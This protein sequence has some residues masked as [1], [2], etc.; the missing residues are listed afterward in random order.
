MAE[1]HELLGLEFPEMSERFDRF[2]E[3]LGYLQAA[4][5]PGDDGFAGQHYTLAARPMRPKPRHLP[6]VVGG[7]GPRRTPR[8]AGT[9]AD[10]FNVF[11]GDPDDI[12]IRVVRARDAASAAGRDPAALR[13]SMMGA[14]ITGTTEA[15]YRDNL[16]KI[17]AAHPF[18]QDAA[19]YEATLKER[20]AP[21]G[22]GSQVRETLAAFEEAG[23]QRFYVQY[24]GPFEEPLMEDL[25]DSLR[26]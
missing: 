8:L 9:Y 20:G 16:A 2:E 14:A 4:F 12:A 11:A 23:V 13:I 15:S 26:G 21:V 1:E 7:N 5:G 19:A 3:A 22:V 24:F 25:F 18:N 10:E 6:I 17:A